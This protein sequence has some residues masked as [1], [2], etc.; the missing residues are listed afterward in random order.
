MA[1]VVHA[2]LLCSPIVFSYA[3]EFSM[4]HIN[5]EKHFLVESNNELRDYR[6]NKE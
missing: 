3:R 1:N 5:H 2:C 4:E 6:D